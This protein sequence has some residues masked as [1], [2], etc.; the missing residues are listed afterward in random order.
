MLDNTSMGDGD[1]RPT[2]SHIL[3]GIISFKDFKVQEI[4]DTYS[5]D[6]TQYEQ[7]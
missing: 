7:W 4:L 6:V 5:R 3:Q 2:Y 1:G